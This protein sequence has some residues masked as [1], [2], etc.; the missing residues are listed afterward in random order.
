M[1]NLSMLKK[2]KKEIFFFVIL[3][4]AYFAFR[5]INISKIPIFTDEAIY[6]WWAQT[7]LNDANWRFISLVDGKQ[8]LFVWITMIFMKVIEDPLIAGRFVSVASGFFT[9]LGL[10][11]LSFELFRKRRYSVISSILYIA[12]PFAHVYDRMALMDGMVG[13]FAVWAIYFSVLLARRLSLSMSYTLGIILG[14]G[15]LT[16]SSGSLV[17]YMLPFTLLLSSIRKNEKFKTFLKWVLLALFSFLIAEVIYNSLRLSPYFYIIKLKNADFVYPLSEWI[18]HPLLSIWPNSTT[19]FTWFIQYFNIYFLLLL[20]AFLRKDFMRE[21]ILLFLY[22]LLPLSAFAIFAKTLFPRYEYAM[23]LSLIPIA[24]Y[25]F[26]VISDVI[27][28]KLKLN[29]FY[30]KGALLILILALPVWISVTLS[31]NPTKALIPE[32]DLSQYIN[33]WPAGWGVEESVDFFKQEASNKKIVVATQGTFGL[34]PYAYDIYL[35]YNPNIRVEG[36]WPINDN[37]PSQLIDLS[38][39]AE[40]F[41]VFYQPCPSCTNQ[42]Y[43]P[44]SWPVERIYKSNKGSL[45]VYRFVPQN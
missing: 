4:V 26:Y 44:S 34:L 35:R 22:F 20:V 36:Y 8:P 5:I 12:Y 45:A 17:A 9:M 10:Y 30:L 31:T 40:T 6:L 7:G 21:K 43:P 25:G 27:S 23:T 3:A 42:F 16:K 33:N 39:N 13:T 2:Y 24:S 1:Y 11:L 29:A 28:N 14:A 41:V 37:P 18:K 38:K 19:L 32:A 15:M